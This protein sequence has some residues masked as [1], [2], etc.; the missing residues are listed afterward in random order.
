MVA[1]FTETVILR[2][3][4]TQATVA[5][6]DGDVVPEW[7]A[8]QVGPHVTASDTRVPAKKAAVSKSEK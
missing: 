3:P 7:A 5:F 1:K 6:F 8:D 4:G 2:E